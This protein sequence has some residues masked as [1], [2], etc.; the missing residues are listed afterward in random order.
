ML[1]QSHRQEALSRAY[2]HAIAA[3]CGLG[4]SFRDFDYGID[5]SVHDIIRKGRRYAESGFNL[6]IQAKS[7]TT[8]NI[9]ATHILY[10]LEI[11]NY[12]DLRDPDVG[13]PR[14]LVVLLMPKEE[15]LWTEQTENYLALKQ[16]AFWMSLRGMAA[17][18][19]TDTIR[20]AIPRTNVFAIAALL[21]LMD[22]V[23]KREK[24]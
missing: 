8:A 2:I 5:L 24:L 10:D 17:T 3:R 9:K 18:T 14:V 7:T 22:K 4:C 20:V 13:C 6:D 12:D 19:N 15:A 11:K 1:I 16:C 21:Q 23:R